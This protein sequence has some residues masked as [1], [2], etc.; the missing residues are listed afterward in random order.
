MVKNIGI[1]EILLYIIMLKY[2]E[3]YLKKKLLGNKF[4]F[5]GI[6]I[7]FLEFFNLIIKK[8]VICIVYFVGLV[9]CFVEKNRV[10]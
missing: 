2:I 3:R 5:I 4:L 8:I 6:F 1:E 9:I 10:W 7:L